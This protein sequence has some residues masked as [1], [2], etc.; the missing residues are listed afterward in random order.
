MLL[1]WLYYKSQTATSARAD[2]GDATFE[3]DWRSR[4]FVLELGINRVD[5]GVSVCSAQLASYA[6]DSEMAYAEHIPLENVASVSLAADKQASWG[7][8]KFLLRTEERDWEMAAANEATAKEWVEILNSI[9]RPFVPGRPFRNDA[10]SVWC[11]EI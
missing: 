2:G 3:E 11:F 1:G 10:T 8:V 5:V 9:P 6:S 4:Y 7:G